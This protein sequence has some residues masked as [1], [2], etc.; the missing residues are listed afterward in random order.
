[1]S[2]NLNTCSEDELYQFCLASMNALRNQYSTFEETAQALIEHLYTDLHTSEGQPYFKLLRMF[3]TSSYEELPPSLKPLAQAEPQHWLN[4]IGTMGAEPAWCQRQ[5]SQGHQSI[6]ITSQMSPMLTEAFH[7]MGLSPTEW[8][9][10]ENHLMI[11]DTAQQGVRYFHV[12]TALGS[13]Y[14]PAQDFVQ[15]YGVASVIGVGTLF[16]SGSIGIIL[17]FAGQKIDAEMARKIATM[18]PYLF[19]AVARLDSKAIWLS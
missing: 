7:Q 5:S 19:T 10:K 9:D 18:A 1:M 12:E 13:P 8:L 14:I 17:G 6:P 11:S 15:A 16:A 4:L 2:L 3:R